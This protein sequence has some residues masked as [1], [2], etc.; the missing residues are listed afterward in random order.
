MTISPGSQATSSA[1][2]P[3]KS[4]RRELPRTRLTLLKSL[5]QKKGTS[6]PRPGT[7][8]PPPP[9]L[10]LVVMPGLRLRKTGRMTIAAPGLQPSLPVAR[11]RGRMRRRSSSLSTGLRPSME[12]TRQQARVR[13]PTIRVSSSRTSSPITRGMVPV[14]SRASSDNTGSLASSVRVASPVRMPARTLR[15][16]SPPVRGRSCP[17]APVAPMAGLVQST[18]PAAT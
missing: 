6:R 10:C 8:G 4:R 1:G 7:R 2:P 17:S 14:L 3:I 15:V 11:P 5:R 13:L 12:L 9:S 16:A 18:T